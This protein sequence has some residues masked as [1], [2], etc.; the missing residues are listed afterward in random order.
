MNRDYV[1]RFKNKVVDEECV[2]F[3]NNHKYSIEQKIALAELGEC[4]DELSSDESDAVRFA[5]IKAIDKILK[6]KGVQIFYTY[7]NDTTEY[8]VIPCR[9][10]KILKAMTEDKSERIRNYALSVLNW[11]RARAYY[12]KEGSFTDIS[13]DLYVRKIH[14]KLMN[15][16]INPIPTCYELGY[17]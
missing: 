5:V 9:E 10:E 1:D 6:N 11:Q 16:A 17:L 8:F 15:N 13:E 4:L 3:E 7:K 12:K 14:K 2:Y